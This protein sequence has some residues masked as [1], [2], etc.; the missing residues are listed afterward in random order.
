MDVAT[1]TANLENARIT[2]AKKT[3]L[4]YSAARTAASDA[5]AE[6]EQVRQTAAPGSPELMTASQQ[7]MDAD[8]KV[9]QLQQQLRSDPA[10]TA[11][12]QVL[13]TAKAAGK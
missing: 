8:A 13:K 11:A 10:V 9:I 3:G 1:A 12:E 4:D 5:K 7:R 6:Y 2:A